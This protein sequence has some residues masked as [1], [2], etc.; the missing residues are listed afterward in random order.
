M[1]SRT[2]TRL[3]AALAGVLALA[4][5]PAPA[6]AHAHLRSAQP[7]VDGTARTGVQDVRITYTE[8]VEP[9]FCQV[10]VTGPDGKPVPAAAPSTDPA[11]AKILVLHLAQPLAPG[12]YQVEWHA[13]SVDTHKTEGKYGFTVAP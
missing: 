4:A 12:A 10:T 7:A 5:P 2:L 11:D 13:T 6:F 8:A 1:T 3:S 9:R